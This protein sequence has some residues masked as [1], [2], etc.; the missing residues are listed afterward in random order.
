MASHRT[1]L[2]LYGSE[3]GNAQDMA[4]QLGETFE[5]LHFQATVEEMDAVDLVK[6]LNSSV[7]SKISLTTVTECA[8]KAPASRLCRVHHWP[9]RYAT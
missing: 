8:F 7:L 2:V 1:A 9:R 3:T 5:R 4:E 6:S